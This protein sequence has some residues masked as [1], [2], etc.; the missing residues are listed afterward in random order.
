M[1]FSLEQWE[2]EGEV[3]VLRA[4]VMTQFLRDPREFKEYWLAISQE[5]Q[6]LISQIIHQIGSPT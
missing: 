6:H 4:A 3:Y 1:G 2:Q 5:F